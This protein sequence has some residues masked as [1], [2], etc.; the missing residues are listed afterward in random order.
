MRATE[1]VNPDHLHKYVVRPA[2]ERLGLPGGVVA[3]AL[4]MATAAQESHFRHLHQLGK[5][6]VALSIWQIE[7][8]TAKD[9][10]RRAKRP[11]L[12]NLLSFVT[13]LREGEAM[14]EDEI[15]EQLH[16]NLYLGAAFCRLVYYLKPFELPDL[17]TW[18]ELAAIYKKHYNSPKGDALPSEFLLNAKR[19]ELGVMFPEV[20]G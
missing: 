5:G 4:V 3:E 1:G 2:L 8:N 17:P 19:F 20:R 6:G 15:L 9:A 11:T 16:G 7:P 13:G 12:V 14:P 18:S 10:L